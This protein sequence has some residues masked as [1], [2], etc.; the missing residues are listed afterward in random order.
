[1]RTFTLPTAL[2]NALAIGAKTWTSATD[3]SETRYYLT[4]SKARKLSGVTYE[5]RYYLNG[6]EVDALD[7]LAFTD[8]AYYLTPDGEV[9]ASR[10]HPRAKQIAA[11]IQ[12]ALEKEQPDA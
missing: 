12:S 6:E 1:M 9:R 4:K 3:P 7:A 10:H 5:V 8:T 2:K 11:L